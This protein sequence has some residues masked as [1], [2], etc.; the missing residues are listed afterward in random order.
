M[1]I[2]TLIKSL[3]FVYLTG[4]VFIQAFQKELESYLAASVPETLS[5]Y[6]AANSQTWVLEQKLHEINDRYRR[7]LRELSFKGNLIVDAINKHEDFMQKLQSFM[8]WLLEAERWLSHE[9]QRPIP[10]DEQNI[11]LMIKALEVC[12]GVH[13]LNY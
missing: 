13:M 7:L 8:P 10:S 1:L 5:T 3:V 12:F 11:A 6:S 9:V 4:I 2:R